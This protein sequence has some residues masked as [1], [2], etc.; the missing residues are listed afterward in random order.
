M[1]RGRFDIQVLVVC[2][3]V[4]A[5]SALITPG[6]EVLTLSGYELPPMCAYKILFGFECPGCGMTRSFSFMGHFDFG[7]AW[8]MNRLGPLLWIMVAVQIPYRT[9]RL[10]RQYSD[11]IRAS[12]S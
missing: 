6:T 5:L 9:V 3:I 7:A 2:T 8:G 11:H 4:V 12:R 1:R 10:L